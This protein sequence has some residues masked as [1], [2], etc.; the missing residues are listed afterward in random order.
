MKILKVLFI[1]I[2]VLSFNV[3]ASDIGLS[4]H[5]FAVNKQVLS[6]EYVNYMSHG[7]GMG[8]EA[9]YFN[10]IDEDINF[11]AG[12]GVTNGDRA[13]RVFAGLDY[14]IYPDYDSQ[15]RV[16]VKGLFDTMDFDGTRVNSFGIAPTISKGFSFWENEAFPYLALPMKIS[17]NQDKDTY[18]SSTAVATGITAPMNIDGMSKLVANLE[19]NM[20]L[21]NSYTG[22]MLGVSLPLQ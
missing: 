21:G 9:K 22:I 17:L 5:P 18:K 6:T 10:R 13:N 12:F 4:T 1:A 2:T 16:S 15:P 3:K 8:I 7:T 14:M 20:D 19:V 11:E